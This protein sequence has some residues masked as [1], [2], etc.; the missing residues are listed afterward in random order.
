MMVGVRKFSVA[1]SVVC[2]LSVVLGTAEPVHAETLTI[3]AAYSLKAAFQEILPMFER[4]Y[5]STVRGRLRSVAH[6]SPAN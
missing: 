1:V 6:A 2:G 5:G 4:E 3:G